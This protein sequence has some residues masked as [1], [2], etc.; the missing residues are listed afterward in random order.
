[1]AV[2]EGAP[3]SSGRRGDEG[4]RE[5]PAPRQWFFANLREVLP[6]S[7]DLSY[8]RGMK[9]APPAAVL[10]LALA[11]PLLAHAGDEGDLVI[12]KDPFLRGEYHIFEKGRRVGSVRQ[13]P[14]DPNRYHLL[15]EKGRREKTIRRNPFLE[16]QFDILDDGKRLGTLRKDPFLEG[17]YR[18][19]DDKGRRRGRLRQDPFL[20][21]QFR[22][23]KDD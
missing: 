17:E 11:L 10:A 22:F 15:D 2:G 13:D 6:T 8:S 5:K 20:E 7:R 23:E 21:D 12:R 16:D 18:L 1:M 3:T 9:F 14:F 4:F 19:F